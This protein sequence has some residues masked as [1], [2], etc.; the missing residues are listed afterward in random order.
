MYCPIKLNSSVKSFKSHLFEFK[1][2]S[3]NDFKMFGIVDLERDPLKNECSFN[4]IGDQLNPRFQTVAFQIT[5]CTHLFLFYSEDVLIRFDKI[6]RF[7]KLGSYGLKHYL[8][9]GEWGGNPGK[10]L[11]EIPLEVPKEYFFKNVSVY[12]EDLIQLEKLYDIYFKIDSLEKNEL[13]T[14]RWIYSMSG[15]GIPIENRFID[16]FILLEMIYVKGNE[17]LNN[18]Y[19]GKVFDNTIKTL[20]VDAAG[21]KLRLAEYY[22]N[23]NN[24]MHGR[25]WEKIERND[26][27]FLATFAH[28]SMLTHIKSGLNC[29]E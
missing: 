22:K 4:Y 5:G 28:A 15:D 6:L 8:E 13:I 16:I 12:E 3:A 23:R 21:I 10:M 18:C 29:S 27:I 14:K 7:F 9:I 25:K 1:E 24:I 11:R 20:K 17:K 2:M 19:H 26:I